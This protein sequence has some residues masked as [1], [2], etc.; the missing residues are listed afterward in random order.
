MR[1]REGWRE[2]FKQNRIKPEAYEEN[3]ALGGSLRN[4]QG[5]I[6]E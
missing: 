1:E 5:L 6:I 3:A 2:D 4:K